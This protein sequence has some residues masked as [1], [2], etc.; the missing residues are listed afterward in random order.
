MPAAIA[1]ALALALVI[2]LALLLSG[3]RAGPKPPTPA[4]AQ[5]LPAGMVLVSGG[6]FVMGS[7]T[8]DEYEK[9]T[10]KV[11]LKPFLIDVC[12]VTC[13]DYEKFVKATNHRAPPAWTN[14]ACA[15]GAVRNPVTGV[16]WYDAAAY[17]QWA[18]KRLPTEAEWELAA[19]GKDGR[20]YPWGNEWRNNAANAGAASAGHVVDVGS[21]P[22]G[23]SPF[24]MLDMVGNAWEWTASD[25]KDYPGGR[26]TEQTLGELKV[27]RGGF[28]GSST[29]KATTTFRR[30][31]DSRDAPSGY[32]N[33][34][35]RC[36]KDV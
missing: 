25:L 7:D 16:D 22:D 28:W 32:K 4:Q 5:P 3:K 21:F 27:I 20:I 15:P 34:G 12:E 6:E 18:G 26:L 17:A 1:V 35:F 36:A 30:G 19:R 31:W 23:K 29:P 14:G 13:G 24:G 9:P 8:G 33:T 10:H 2:T 11:T